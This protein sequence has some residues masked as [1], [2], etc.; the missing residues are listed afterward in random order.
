M[1]SGE[2]RFGAE[3]RR[4]RRE[5]GK[6][7]EDLAAIMG[8]SIPYVSDIER[9]QRSPPPR[10]VIAKVLTAWGCLD[11]LDYFAELA[12]QHRGEFQMAPKNADE[13]RVLVALERTLEA[14]LNTNQYEQI[15]ELLKRIREGRHG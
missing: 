5:K 12:V 14:D 9:G 11:N 10:A 1:T 3:L 8:V 2:V 7:L 15:V 13:R 6:T 4:V